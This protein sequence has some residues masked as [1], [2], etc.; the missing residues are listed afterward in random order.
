MVLS[1]IPSKSNI[2][3]LSMTVKNK[4]L[5]RYT[6]TTWIFMWVP[7][8]G[9]QGLWGF[10]FSILYVSAACWYISR[11]NFSRLPHLSFELAC[12]KMCNPCIG[13]TVASAIWRFCCWQAK[14]GQEEY[15]EGRGPQKF[16]WF[17]IFFFL[18]LYSL[19]QCLDV[20]SGRR[21]KNECKSSQRCEC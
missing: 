3:A 15:G 2:R 11:H 5:A 21:C 12:M 14:R 4:Q 9:E 20:P 8:P 16:R 17:K 10:F 18:F 13:R 1:F 6:C 19:F 7:S